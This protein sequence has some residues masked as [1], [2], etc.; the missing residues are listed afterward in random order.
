MNLELK[1]FLNSLT[2]EEKWDLRTK[3]NLYMMSTSNNYSDPYIFS[4]TE[5]IDNVLSYFRGL[6]EEGEE[7]NKKDVFSYILSVL[8]AMIYTGQNRV[9]DMVQRAEEDRLE[10]LFSYSPE[11]REVIR[12]RVGNDPDFDV[13]EEMLKN[14]D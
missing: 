2:I 13:L 6:Q 7:V 11:Q 10:R 5:V 3:H 8:D 4:F 1:H 9:E 12:S 14:S